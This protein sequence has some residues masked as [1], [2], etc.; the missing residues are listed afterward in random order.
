MLRDHYGDP[1]ADRATSDH[2]WEQTAPRGPIRPHRH[3]ATFETWLAELGGLTPS[4]DPEAPAPSLPSTLAVAG[5]MIPSDG[6]LCASAGCTRPRAA[7]RPDSRAD[8]APF[9][10]ECRR[11][12]FDAVR[13]GTIPER[14][15]AVY[16]AMAPRPVHE[17]FGSTP[18]EAAAIARVRALRAD[19]MT[20]TAIVERL[21]EEGLRSRGGKP[22]GFARV[23]AMASAEVSL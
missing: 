6:S 20:F 15:L 17:P 7:M 5:R 10:R 12:A 22:H 13:D 18:D 11:R 16:A 4:A 19:G 9:C 2:L 8:L 3:G 21:R 14:D 1:I 23:H